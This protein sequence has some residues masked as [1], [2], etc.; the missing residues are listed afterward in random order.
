[1]TEKLLL[2]LI[3]TFDGNGLKMSNPEIGK[4]LNVSRFTVS[5][6]LS[7]LRKRELIHTEKAGSKYRKIRPDMDNLLNLLGSQVEPFYLTDTVNLLNSSSSRLLNSLGSQHKERSKVKRYSALF[8]QFWSAYPKKVGPDAARKAF[9]KRKPDEELLQK[10]LA[11]LERQRQ[12]QQWQDDD[13]R[14]IPNPTRWLNEA[15]WEDEGVAQSKPEPKP[16]ERDADGLT[17]K[18]RFLIDKVGVSP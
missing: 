9:T 5:N 6:T 1:M 16:L 7:N 2:S 18:E 11:A 15:R 10:M 14:Y 13:G 8:D 12:S 3:L 17:P 4:A